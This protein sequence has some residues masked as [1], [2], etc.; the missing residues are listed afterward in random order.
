M[1]P[2]HS[3]FL[4]GNLFPSRRLQVLVWFDC[5]CFQRNQRSNQLDLES[6]DNI[7]GL[8][9]LQKLSLQYQPCRQQS[10][11]S[12]KMLILTWRFSLHQA[13]QE[14]EEED[15]ENGLKKIVLLIRI[16]N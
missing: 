4:Q 3:P 5:P 1:A 10:V 6:P 13:S 7:D 12:K 16:V 2:Y 11:S 14:K 9:W 8:Y 15:H